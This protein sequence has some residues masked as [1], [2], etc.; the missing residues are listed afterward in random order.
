MK[1]ISVIFLILIFSLGCIQEKKII[2]TKNVE[3]AKIDG[4]SL[5]LDV[6]TSNES[7]ELKPLILWIHGGSWIDGSKEIDP[8]VVKEFIKQGYVFASTNYRLSNTAKWPAQ[9]NDVKTAI[10]YLKAN[11][12]TYGFDKEK[13][14]VIGVSA[15]GHLASLLGTTKEIEKF[16]GN[17][18]ENEKENSEV[19]AVVNIFGPTNLTTIQ[20]QLIEAHPK[21][22]FNDN[23]NVL[24]NLLGCNPDDCY[25]KAWSASPQKYVSK[26][27]SVFLILHGEKDNIV[28]V[29]QNIEFNSELKNAR[30][31]TKLIISKKFGHTAEIILEN[32]EKILNFLKAN[33]K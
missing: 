12:N 32:R 8:L 9:I 19:K 25:E 6:Y 28:P 23:F 10:R 3:Y 27:D 30:V 31:E 14:G 5:L 18:D 11:S 33:L 26:D 4:E 2:E 21:I 7:K 24:T 29:Q 16:E 13:I 17:I 1:K 15:G 20:E 22:N